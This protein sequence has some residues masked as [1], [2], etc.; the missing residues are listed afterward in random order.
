LREK[1]AA[2]AQPS[3]TWAGLHLGSSILG[4]AVCLF[5]LFNP[6]AGL[7]Q[8]PLYFLATL[9]FVKLLVLQ[10]DTGHYSLLPTTT[11]NTWAGRICS[12]AT[13]VPFECW[14]REHQAHHGHFAKIDRRTNGDILLLTVGEYEEL[15]GFGKLFYRI[16]RHPL[17]FLI[18]APLLYFLL[19]CRF[20]F[21]QER[22]SRNSVLLHNLSL[23]LVYGALVVEFGAV[24]AA[25]VLLPVWYLAGAIAVAVFLVQHQS[26]KTDWYQNTDWQFDRAC[27]DG[28]S[29]FQLSC[30]MEW[31]FCHV[32]YHH[33]HH[34]NPK[35]PSYRL[36]DC[37]HAISDQLKQPSNLTVRDLMN[38]YQGA[39]WSPTEERIIRFKDLA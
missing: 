36:Q 33:I 7:L 16:Q 13:L 26:T 2:F 4:Y 11:M 9:F 25:C 23:V 14:R 21:N 8:L 31:F 15:T 3:L 5:A 27:L 19:R 32:G 39:L 18:M 30:Y 10:H 24:R 12:I 28:C 38:A 17:Y 35:V 6:P 22:T 20:S 34:M 29:S 37:Y 1:L